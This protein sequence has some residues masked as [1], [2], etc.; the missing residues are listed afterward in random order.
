MKIDNELLAE[1]V[2]NHLATLHPT[3]AIFPNPGNT[4]LYV[5]HAVLILCMPTTTRR[6]HRKKGERKKKR[7]TNSQ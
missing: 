7:L 3:S 2:G 6:T 4:I 1:Q 5:P